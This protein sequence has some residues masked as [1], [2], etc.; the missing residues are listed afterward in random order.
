MWL[1]TLKY[2]VRRK[3]TAQV[4]FTSSSYEEALEWMKGHR[5]IELV[6]HLI[7]EQEAA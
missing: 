3:T 4:L 2:E 1:K 6:A 5:S 7:I